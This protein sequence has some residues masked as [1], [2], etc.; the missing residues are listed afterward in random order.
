MISRVDEML[1]DQP[2]RGNVFVRLNQLGYRPGDVKRAVAFSAGLLGDAF[3]VVDQ[4][5]GQ[6]VFEGPVRTLAGGWGRFDA[7]GELDFTALTRPGRYRLRIEETKSE[8]FQ[9]GEAVSRELPSQLLGFLRQQRCGYNP[10]LDVECHQ[11][12]GRTACGPRAPGTPLD[13]RGGWHDAA[14]LLKYLLTSGN[15]TAQ[16]LLAW[17]LHRPAPGTRADDQRETLFPDLIDARGVAGTNGVP[18]L[19]DEA[20]WGLEWMLKL[21]PTSEELYHQVADDRDHYGLRLPH[22]DQADYGWG[23][24]GARVVYCADGQPQGLGR[25][26]SDS[27]GLANLAGRYAAAMALAWQIWKDDPTHAAFAQRCLQF[28]REVYA[29]GRRM[30]GVQQGN[31]YGAPYRYAESTW[32]DDMEWGAAELFRATGEPHYLAEASQYAR[33]AAATSWMGREQIGHYE[34]YPFFNAGHYRLHGLADAELR[35]LLAG[36]Y[37][38][39]LD[40]CAAAARTNPYGIGVP[41]IWCS[42]NLLVALVTQAQLYQSMTGDRRYEEFTARHRDWLFG[43]NPW[44]TTMFTGV[45]RRY[46]TDVHLLTTRLTGREIP[47]GLVD[48]PVKESIFQSLKGVSLSQPDA[49]AA[50]QD[51]RA[52]YHDDWH[53]YASNEPT[54]DGTA[55]SILMLSVLELPTRPAESE[56]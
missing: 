48:G 7:H 12:D 17:E 24:G 54:M 4:A 38:E 16:L 45:G 26:P 22:H 21:H 51:A 6:I 52:V 50:F 34:F 8:P 35:E 14:D 39:G 49:F 47:G 53:D 33:L 32:T 43:R 27:T 19:L 44:G 25:F 55:S 42:N 15:A 3:E 31:S 28:G 2:P 41:F 13:A 56:R 40:R 5:S 9:V 29:L 23:P 1:A 20:R 11:A 30:E 10:W 36:F 46:P 18:D 37:R